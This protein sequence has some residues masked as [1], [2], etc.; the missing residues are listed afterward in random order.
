MVDNIH[1]NIK[2]IEDIEKSERGAYLYYV[3]QRGLECYIHAV[4]SMKDA[5][6]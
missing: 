6:L 5:K 1:R 2:R 3:N 4:L